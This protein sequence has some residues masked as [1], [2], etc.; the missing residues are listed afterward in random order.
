MAYRLFRDSDVV[1]EFCTDREPH[2]NPASELFELNEKWNLTLCLSAVSINNIIHSQEIPRTPKNTRSV[3]DPNGDDRNN[4]DDQKEI[5]QALKNDF[6][7]YQD[8]V[9]YSSALNIKNLD[10]II[11][12][13]TKDYRHSSIA[14]MTP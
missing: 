5:I 1:I 11:T 7:D 14:V 13:N 12:R 6:P 2:A 10:T 8:S 3:G 4:R 9:Q